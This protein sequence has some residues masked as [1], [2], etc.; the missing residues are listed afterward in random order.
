MH[1]RVACYQFQP[2]QG[3]EVARR[4][5][6]GLLPIFARQPGFRSYTV[7]LTERDTGY[8]LSVW[9]TPGQATAAVLAAAAWVTAHVA[10]LVVAVQN[11][12]GEVAFAQV[13]QQATPETS[14]SGTM[15]RPVPAASSS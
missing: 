10:R 8:S 5:A 4:A 3:P 2:G 14:G 13:A 11:H 6:T 12:V 15:E 1:A 7:F 9:E